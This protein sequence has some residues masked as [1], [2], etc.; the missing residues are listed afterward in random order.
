MSLCESSVHP[1]GTDPQ[2]PRLTLSSVILEADVAT[3]TLVPKLYNMDQEKSSSQ[4]LLH[5]VILIFF[6]SSGDGSVS[7]SLC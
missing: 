2:F 3:L 1:F 6:P 7:P 4:Q 5:V